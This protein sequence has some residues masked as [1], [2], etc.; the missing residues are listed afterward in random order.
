MTTRTLVLAVLAVG[1]CETAASRAQAPTDQWFTLNK[2]GP[3][4][5]AAMT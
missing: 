4:V 1:V 2:I 3:N 5:W